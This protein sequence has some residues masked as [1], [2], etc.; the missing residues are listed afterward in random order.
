M[1]AAVWTVVVCDLADDLSRVVF[2]ESPSF[3]EYATMRI[4]CR[5]DRCAT[6]RKPSPV[7]VKQTDP[8][9][10]TEAEFLFDHRGTT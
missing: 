6:D 9:F 10:W 8:L 1:Q 4:P 3:S 7:L 5:T 2:A